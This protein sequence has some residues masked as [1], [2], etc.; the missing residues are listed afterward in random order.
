MSPR[1]R[2]SPEGFYPNLSARDIVRDGHVLLLRNPAGRKFGHK[3]AVRIESGWSDFDEIPAA[4]ARVQE[5][6]RARTAGSPPA[7][8]PEFGYLSPEP[9]FCGNNLFIACM[10]HLEGLSLLGDLKYALA[11]L[12][13]VR[14]NYW[15]FEAEA[16]RDTAHIYRLENR[17]SLGLSADALVRRVS[18]VYQGLVQQELNARL[19]LVEEDSRI[20]AD[21]IAR[22]LAVLRAARLLSPWELA[23]MLSPIRL[24]ASMGFI[25]GIDKEEIDN[26]TLAQFD[27]PPDRLDIREQERARDKRDAKFADR[28]N[29][30]F[31]RVGLNATGRKLLET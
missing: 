1:R 14:I 15:G 7:W 27:E 9:A 20:L 30:R 22:S 31:A 28:M 8:D 26:F 4:F 25:D 21:S 16:I 10:V 5:E 12:D 23:D 3:D 19:H 29:K 13:A 6:E 2:P 24:A 11:G 18:A 17:F